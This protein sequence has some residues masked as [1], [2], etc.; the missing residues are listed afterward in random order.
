MFNH[1]KESLEE[2]DLEDQ[3][4]QEQEELEDCPYDG[5]FQGGTEICDF[6]PYSEECAAETM[7]RFG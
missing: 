6:C 7:K 3:E 1:T 5:F 4:Y 2:Q